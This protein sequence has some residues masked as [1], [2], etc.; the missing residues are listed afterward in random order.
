MSPQS[1]RIQN[2]TC[3]HVLSAKNYRLLGDLNPLAPCCSSRVLVLSQHHEVAS[4]VSSY[5]LNTE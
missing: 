4:F 5:M 3:T 1:L 2:S